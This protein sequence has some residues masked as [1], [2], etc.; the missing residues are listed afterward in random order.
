MARISLGAL[1]S[2]PLLLWG[3]RLNS[4]LLKH[5]LSGRDRSVAIHRDCVAVNR[6]SLSRLPG[7]GA[8]DESGPD[9]HC[10][11]REDEPRRMI[12]LPAPLHFSPVGRL[13][14][15]MEKNALND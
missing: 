8:G 10:W 1:N 5:G 2:M 15:F 7:S 13:F 11:M 6:S 14:C 9:H 12:A 3:F 4:S